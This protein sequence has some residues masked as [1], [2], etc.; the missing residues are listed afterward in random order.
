MNESIG[1]ECE[2]EL[3]ADSDSQSS[4]PGSLEFLGDLAE[5]WKKAHWSHHLVHMLAGASLCQALWCALRTQR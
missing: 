2:I 3:L 1:Q 4:G 5:H